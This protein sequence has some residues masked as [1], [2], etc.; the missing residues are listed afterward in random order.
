MIGGI[1][2]NGESFFPAISGDGTSVLFYSSSSN[3]DSYNYDGIFNYNLT[4]GNLTRVSFFD[5]GQVMQMGMNY[6]I[7]SYNGRYS[8][9]QTFQTLSFNG[10]PTMIYRRDN[11]LQRTVVVSQNIFGATPND[12]SYNPTCSDDGRHVVF[13]STATDLIPSY[14]GNGFSNIFLRD[15]DLNTTLLISKGY[16]GPLNGGIPDAFIS[17]DFNWLLFTTNATNVV[18]GITV[19]TSTYQSYLMNMLSGETS[20]VSIDVGS[21]QSLPVD[22]LYPLI[23]RNDIYVSWYDFLFLFFIINFVLSLIFFS[24]INNFF[25]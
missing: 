24:V 18:S 16:N 25:S 14:T 13:Q 9:L 17:P 20:L 5:D 23:S 4:T 8:F 7:P 19:A 12:D 15:L 21:N 11:W 10:V 2:G 6:G 3:F 22:A 1:L